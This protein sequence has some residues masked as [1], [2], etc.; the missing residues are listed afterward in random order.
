MAHGSMRG[1]AELSRRWAVTKEA[2]SLSALDGS[3]SAIDGDYSTADALL[4]YATSPK[5]ES[6]NAVETS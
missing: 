4:F 3:S 1:M 2:R 5:G 6:S